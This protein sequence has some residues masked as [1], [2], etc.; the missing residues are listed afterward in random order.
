[1]RLITEDN[2]D[3][4]MS[5]SQGGVTEIRCLTHDKKANYKSVKELTTSKQLKDNR[6]LE[7]K[8]FLKQPMTEEFQMPTIIS[9]APNEF[10]SMTGFGMGINMATAM[11]MNT[12]FDDG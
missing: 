7:R 3:Q 8:E 10:E 12:G 6:E 5:L 2:I 4:L 1:M 11:A 9:N